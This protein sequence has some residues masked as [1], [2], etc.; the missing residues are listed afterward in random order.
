MRAGGSSLVRL[1]IKTIAAKRQSSTRM[2]RTTAK[3]ESI[4]EGGTSTTDRNVPTHSRRRGARPLRERFNKFELGLR[5]RFIPADDF[6]KNVVR[7]I[8]PPTFVLL[9]RR[10][11]QNHCHTSDCRLMSTSAGPL[12]PGWAMGMHPEHNVPYYYNSSTQTTQWHPPAA[13]TAPAACAPAYAQP[14]VAPPSVQPP[15]TPHPP[16]PAAPLPYGQQQPQHA[17]QHPQNAYQQPP[18]AYHQPPHAYQP[19]A[20]GYQQPQHAYQ[21]PQNAYQQPPNAY[22][23]PPYGAQP[24]GYPPA[25]LHHLSNGGGAAY[26]YGSNGMP[27]H[28]QWPV[29]AAPHGCGAGAAAARPQMFPVS[30]GACYRMLAWTG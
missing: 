11:R 13:L 27:P 2:T 1:R 25:P 3:A 10:R 29:A 20:N 9:A 23:P 26:P 14:Q 30:N 28:P 18:N 16:L 15:P 19:P 5:Q 7:Q 6:V 22:R 21:H 4:A 12:P 24:P 8:P 17:Y